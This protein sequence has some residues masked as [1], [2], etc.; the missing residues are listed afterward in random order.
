MDLTILSNRLS[1]T[2]TVGREICLLGREI[3]NG[4]ERIAHSL[5]KICEK[6][7]AEEAEGEI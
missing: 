6:V 3:R 2:V 7:E 1:E 5:E 4:V